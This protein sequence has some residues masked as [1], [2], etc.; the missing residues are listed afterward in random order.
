METAGLEAVDARRVLV[1][2]RG[3]VAA[4]CDDL[5][6]SFFVRPWGRFFVPTC[7]CAVTPGADAVKAGRRCSGAA[8]S[9]VARPRLDGVELG[10][11]LLLVGTSAI[12]APSAV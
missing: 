3:C 1:L 9:S 8:G 4:L 6:V 12:S 10:V 11:T 2:G 7:L 5:A